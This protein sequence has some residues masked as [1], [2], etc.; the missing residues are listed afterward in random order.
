MGD[1][2]PSDSWEFVSDVPVVTDVD[3]TAPSVV[4]VMCGGVVGF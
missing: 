4:A 3:E 2:E 1:G